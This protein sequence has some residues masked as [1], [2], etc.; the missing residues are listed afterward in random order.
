MN[1]EIT[2]IECGHKLDKYSGDMDERT[3]MNCILINEDPDVI[4]PSMVKVP[5]IHR[6]GYI[7]KKEKK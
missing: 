1:I 5:E 2:C 7:F 6:R 4:K 3:C